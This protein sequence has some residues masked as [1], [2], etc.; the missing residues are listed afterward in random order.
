MNKY[1]VVI[2]VLGVFIIFMMLNNNELK[3]EVEGNNQEIQAFEESEDIIY[4]EAGE[5]AKAFVENYFIYTG[6]PVED[7]VSEFV[8][9]NV[10]KELSFGSSE[11]S[12]DLEKVESSVHQMNVY[13]GEQREGKQKVLILFDNVIE[14]NGVESVAKTIMEVD[15]EQHGEHWKVTEFT[16]NQY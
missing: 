2:G 4:Y 1:W 14:L 3:K 13:Y 9:T 12:N 11:Y 10:L 5:V 16:F 15:V 7:N 8:T 6:H